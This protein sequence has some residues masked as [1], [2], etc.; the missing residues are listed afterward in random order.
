MATLKNI[1]SSF[2]LSTNVLTTT[3]AFVKNTTTIGSIYSTTSNSHYS[4]VVNDIT[5]TTATS[6]PANTVVNQNDNIN[7]KENLLNLSTFSTASSQTTTSANLSSSTTLQTSDTTYTAN[8]SH[9]K[10]FIITQSSIAL[11]VQENTPSIKGLLSTASAKSASVNTITI[12]TILNNFITS[13]ES[14]GANKI[15][16]N[17]S[18][19]SSNLNRLNTTYPLLSNT[20]VLNTITD[21]IRTNLVISDQD[22]N[23]FSEVF[24]SGG[25]SK[26]E[27]GALEDN[28]SSM[29]DGIL[30]KNCKKCGYKNIFYLIEI[31]ALVI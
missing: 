17:S 1:T 22:R 20:S 28:N 13:F 6:L 9:S 21:S 26:L 8:S 7:C 25:G 27:S 16:A 15:G 4:T 23:M 2:L 10:N 29:G 5:T 18:S 19:G 30:E 12:D 11:E 24:E 31:F 14:N 3:T